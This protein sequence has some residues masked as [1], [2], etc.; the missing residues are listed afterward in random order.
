MNGLELLRGGFFPQFH[1]APEAS[2]FFLY[3]CAMALVFFGLALH[4]RFAERMVA[5]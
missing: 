1:A 4:V 3:G 5:Q 2:L